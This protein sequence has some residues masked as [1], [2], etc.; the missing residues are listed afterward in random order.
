MATRKL[1]KPLYSEHFMRK[2]NAYKEIAFKKWLDEG[3]LV[4]SIDE[5]RILVDASK[6]K[7][8]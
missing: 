5:A 3:R 6:L 4:G 2:Y 8:Q 7:R 1:W